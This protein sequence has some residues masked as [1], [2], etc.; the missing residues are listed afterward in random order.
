MKKDL[1][2]KGTK[3]R[4]FKEKKAGIILFFLCASASSWQISSCEAQPTDRS[5]ASFNTE[6]KTK[7]FVIAG[8]CYGN[9]TNNSSLYTPFINALS[10]YGKIHPVSGLYLTGDVVDTSTQ[11]KW[12]WVGSVLKK[13]GVPWSIAPGNHDISPYFFDRIGSD[14]Y[15]VRGSNGHLF[16][17]LN[18]SRSGWSVDSSQIEFIQSE[19]ADLQPEQS[20]FVF[21]H[22]LWWLRPGAEKIQLDSIRPNSFALWDGDSSFW[23]TAWPLFDSL[24]NEIYFFAGDLGSD[25]RVASYFEQHSGNTHFY[26]SGMGS[27]FGDNF[28]VI[29]LEEEGKVDIQRVNF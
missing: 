11:E 19:L 13:T 25:K 4:S 20:V 9:Q 29:R 27:G 8:H 7:Y 26:A 5:D 17:T 6:S 12:D 3:T 18:T 1:G 21:T 15:S 28:L 14:G 16:L 10:V 2:H 23:N 22:Q 24:D